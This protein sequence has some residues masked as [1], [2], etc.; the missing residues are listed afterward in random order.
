MPEKTRSASENSSS[1]KG[2]RP[3]KLSPEALQQLRAL[4]LGNPNATVDDLR[5]LIEQQVGVQ[6][7][8]L[9]MYRYLK[10]AGIHRKRS[11]PDGSSSHK[12]AS[13]RFLPKAPSPY[14]YNE[15]H[16]AP[17]DATHYPGSLTDA[18]WELIA[19]LFEHSGPG[20][21]PRY[22]RRSLVDACCYVVR[23]GCS[24][25]RLPKGLPPWQ[26]VYAH[27]R[28]WTG[29]NLFE[30]MHDRLR[31]MWRIRQGRD[32]APTAAIIDF[33]SVK[34]SA[35]GVPKGDDAGKKVKGSKR[36]LV[37]D[38]LGIL[39]AVLVHPADVQDRDGAQ[40][41]VQ[42]AMDKYPTLQKMYVDA[43]YSGECAERLRRHTSS[44]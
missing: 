32:P 21:P 40:P 15:S 25:R 43:G 12:G 20:A 34:T 18:E 5:L 36:H 44:T 30:R 2:G 39:L 1:S 26:D 27:F 9:S 4:A 29:L 24:W 35:Q 42:G 28:R 16:R 7:C 19:D 8:Q 10:R 13:S 22:P 6:L 31:A 14:G 23:T 11:A 33:Q 3:R 41:V 38:V 17:G 37:V